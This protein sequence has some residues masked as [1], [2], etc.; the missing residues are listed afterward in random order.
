VA[1]EWDGIQE[2]EGAF[3]N[4]GDFASTMQKDAKKVGNSYQ[5]TAAQA[6]EWMEVYPDLFKQAEVTSDGLISLD[7]SVVDEYING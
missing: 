3:E 7:Q 5:L 2:I 1:I 4:V 6:R